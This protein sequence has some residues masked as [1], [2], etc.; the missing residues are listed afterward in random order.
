MN[1]AATCSAGTSYVNYNYGTCQAGYTLQGNNCVCQTSINQAGVT[2]G[3]C[4]AA[5]YSYVQGGCYNN[6]Q[7]IC[8]QGYVY[9]TPTGMCVRVQ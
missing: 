9:V 2:N 4:Q 1:G 3:Q 6:P 8:Y 5:G 7:N